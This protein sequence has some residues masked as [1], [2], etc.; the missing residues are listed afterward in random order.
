[1]SKKTSTSDIE[2]KPD[3]AFELHPHDPV[4]KEMGDIPGD[5]RDAA[6]ASFG[7]MAKRLPPTLTIKK[8]GTIDKNV[9]Q[10][11]IKSTESWRIVYTTEVT[12]K[13]VVLHATQKTTEG[14]DRQLKTVV[15]SRLKSLRDKLKA[16]QQAAKKKK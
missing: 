11:T 2:R 9:F 5:C 4:Q 14:V 16:E 12:G 1:M 7:L 3:L 15:E 6:M 8:L 10:M 13:I